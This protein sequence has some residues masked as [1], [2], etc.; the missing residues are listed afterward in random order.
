MSC[1]VCLGASNCPVCEEPTWTDEELQEK[2]DYEI[3]VIETENINEQEDECR[4]NKS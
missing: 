1:T 4:K 3:E 2:A